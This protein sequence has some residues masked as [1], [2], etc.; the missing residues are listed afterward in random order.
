MQFSGNG[1]QTTDLENG[2][3]QL[4]EGA[5]DVAL[6]VFDE[7]AT[8]PAATRDKAKSLDHQELFTVDLL[9]SWFKP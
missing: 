6:A 5:E 1:Q 3:S 8:S 4:E 9:G 2:D 7:E